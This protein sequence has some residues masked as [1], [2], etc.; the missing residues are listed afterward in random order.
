MDII[1]FI[2][3]APFVL[4]SFILGFIVG[5]IKASDEDNYKP[6]LKEIEKYRSEYNS[7]LEANQKAKKL[8]CFL[9]KNNDL[10][11]KPLGELASIFSSYNTQETN[12]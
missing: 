8:L 11:G 1:D 2:I 6:S 5:R 3:L 9:M 7:L 10:Y 4:P 12:K